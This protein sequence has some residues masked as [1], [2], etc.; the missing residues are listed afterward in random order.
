MNVVIVHDVLRLVMVVT[1]EVMMFL[2]VNSD[3]GFYD[4]LVSGGCYGGG[5]EETN[6][7]V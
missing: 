7:G 1:V 5:D 4:G 3:L 6:N 2:F